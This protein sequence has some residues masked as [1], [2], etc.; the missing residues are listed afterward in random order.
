MAEG[1]RGPLRSVLGLGVPGKGS[2]WLPKAGGVRL[3]WPLQPTAQR[4]GEGGLGGGHGQGWCWETSHAVLGPLGLSEPPLLG[5]RQ[6]KVTSTC[7]LL[8]GVMRWMGHG[9]PLGLA[10]GSSWAS[11]GK[12]GSS[13]RG[14]LARK[15][16]NVCPVPT[17]ATLKCQHATIV[18]FTDGKTGSERVRG[19]ASAQG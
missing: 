8:G 10:P 12:W 11:H 5:Q 19:A 7:C 9:A 1:S 3:A 13:E 4:A 18:A 6:G 17:P 14:A 15:R 2:R 16:V